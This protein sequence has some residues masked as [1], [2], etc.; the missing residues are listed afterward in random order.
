MS[1]YSVKGKGWR[2]DFILKGQRYTSN[3]FTTKVAARQAEAKKREEA[4]KQGR[5][6]EDQEKGGGDE[7][8]RGPSETETGDDP[9][10]HGL[11]RAGQ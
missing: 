6:S 11:F 5:G 10:R 2:Y 8:T 3:W 4:K 1:V 9:N 7:S